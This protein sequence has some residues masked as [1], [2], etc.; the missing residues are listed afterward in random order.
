MNPG[1][2][3]TGFFRRAARIPARRPRYV[4]ALWAL[5]LGLSLPLAARVGEVLTAEPS[6]SADTEAVSVATR[7]ADQ[8]SG[9]DSVSVV[10]V[11]RAA[12]ESD[13]YRARLDAFL[14]DVRHLPAVSSLRDIRDLVPTRAA[15]G[16]FL[17]QLA[18]GG[19]DRTAARQAVATIRKAAAARPELE[20]AMAGGPATT[21]E[22]REVSAR[23]TRRGEAFGLPISL[24]VLIVAF[25]ALVASVL[26]LLVAAT[27]I[28]VALAGVF[29]VGQ[30]FPFAVFTQSIV[31]MLGLATG[32]DYALLT[33]N[34][35][36]EELRAGRTPRDAAEE[37]G[38]TAGKA[39]AF[40]GLTV[41]VAL[42]ALLLAP[43]PYVRSVGVGTMI[44][45]SASVLVSWTALPALLA[46]MGHRVDWL[47][48]TRRTPGTR[49]RVFWRRR[50]E[51]IMARPWTFTVLGTAALVL[52]ALP[53]FWMQLAD[54]GPRGMARGT[55]ART[56]VTALED[57]ELGG[58]LS[59]TTVLVDMGEEG[60]FG[61]SAPRRVSRLTR[62]LEALEPVRSVISP[63]SA[64][65]VPR[66]FLFQYYIDEDLARS[67]D[68]AEL[69]DATVGQ[70]GRYVQLQVVPIG[71]LPPAESAGLA[72]EA[73]RLA[74]SHGLEVQIGGSAAFE[75]AW[76]RVLYSSFPL[77][78]GL[79]FAATLVL[80]GLA[81][82]SVLI[83]IKSIVLNALTVAASYGVITLVFQMGVGAPLLGLDGGLGIV[84]SNVPL[85]VFAIVF[86]LSMDYEVFLVA[87]IFE[88]H[89]RGLS[90]HEAVA[91]ALETTGGVITSAAT[92]MLVVFSV[93]FFSEVVLIKTLG[94]GLAVAI[95][96]DA[97]LV[98]LALVP[99]VMTL[100]GRLN[101]WL[102]AP[103]ARLADRFGLS[104]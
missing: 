19:P 39:V 12:D 35:Y 64:P 51:V 31:T 63:F 57:A 77:T 23:D 5:I 95:L 68:V 27:T 92:V 80:L 74:A 11:V 94:V 10:L 9:G 79:V 32:I 81:F 49:T 87:R 45:M 86:G 84:D 3:P 76:S 21:L 102:P 82:R 42:S 93:F 90:D 7:V 78:L 30:V 96:L 20:V 65:G 8:F 59:A 34:R 85:F 22:L 60:F 17:G 69:V 75:A 50:A 67:S 14:A 1:R 41:V 66:L 47:K 36:R 29:L 54:P 73:R 97:T 91:S 99:A 83:P 62:D 98:R 28:T 38:A 43:L 46:L 61:P 6:L 104:H 33:V 58:F 53:A 88:A 16:T 18:F 44:V 24:L 70:D 52:L 26:P 103:L 4:L 2:P 40:S 72:A 25:G 56:A 15:E 55:E 71:D 37:T 48:V 89:E 100:A 101:W 13:A